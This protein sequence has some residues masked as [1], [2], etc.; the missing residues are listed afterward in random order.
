[1]DEIGRER[2]NRRS[3]KRRDPEYRARQAERSRDWYHRNR[4]R[5]RLRRRSDP[6]YVKRMRAAALEAKW[7]KLGFESIT[8][9]YERMLRLQNGRCAICKRRSERRL[10]VDHCHATN[11]LRSLL[12][13]N[14]NVALGLLG[15]DARRLREAAAY[16]DMW[17]IIH[18]ADRAA[19]PRREGGP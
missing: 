6:A 19:G 17:R 13:R 16:L 5:I 4:E 15:D 18:G 7:R 12:C 14:C 9:W 1:V 10:N 8:Q 3:R 11:M 2:T